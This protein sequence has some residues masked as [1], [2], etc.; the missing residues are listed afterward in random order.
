MN[1][2]QGVLYM[3]EMTE[4]LKTSGSI[5]G[6]LRRG[7]LVIKYPG[8]KKN[9]DYRVS[10]NGKAPKHE[11]IVIEIFN[12]TKEE[13]FTSVVNFLDDV[14]TNGLF[15]TSDLF[16]K[17]FKEK[18]FWITLQ[19]EI[20]YPQPQYAGRR[21]SFQRFYEAALIKKGICSLRE[22][23]KRTNNHGKYKPALYRCNDIIHPSFYF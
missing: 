12:F 6:Y 8:Y 7:N 9:G 10:E 17:S 22:V 19:E 16:S 18:I 2:A 20:N 13:N 15:A 23:I 11:D 5:T 14:Y 3:A 4:K 21:L 1:F